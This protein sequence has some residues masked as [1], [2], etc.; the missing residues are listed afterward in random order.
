MHSTTTLD[1]IADLYDEERQLLSRDDDDWRTADVRDIA[2]D[3]RARL[4]R[5]WDKRRAE[6]VFTYRGPPR[7]I[8]APDPSRRAQIARG[9]PPLPSGGD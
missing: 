6:L 9:I 1:R 2:S 5:M 3:I 7:L 8:S 4:E